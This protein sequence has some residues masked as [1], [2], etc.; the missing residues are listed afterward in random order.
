MLIRVFM[1]HL[2][3]IKTKTTTTTTKYFHYLF[4]SWWF[5]RPLPRPV[6]HTHTKCRIAIIICMQCIPICLV[7][8]KA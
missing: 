1:E 8:A 3:V 2:I 7:L 6:S 5:I 4:I